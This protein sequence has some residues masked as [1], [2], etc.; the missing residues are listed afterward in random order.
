MSSPAQRYLDHL[1]RLSGGIEPQFQPIES[2]TPGLPRVTTI[3]YD[4]VPEPGHV[5]GFTY[6]LSLADHPEWQHGKTELCI[7]VD[8][9][10]IAWPLAIGYLA[11]SLRVECS[12]GYGNLLNFGQRISP[13]SAMNAFVVFAPSVLEPDDYTGIDVGDT[14]INIAGCY[15][16]H[17]SESDY[18]E[19]HGL[20]AFWQLEWDP[21][22][23]T[24][25]PAV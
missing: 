24:R 6:G 20:E 12:F 4:D 19:E 14:T 10:D 15:P 23:V 5:T 22:D 17:E 8:S 21:Y 13:E 25:Q 16:I 1:D 7:S 9:T 11:E 3:S 2:T 18:I